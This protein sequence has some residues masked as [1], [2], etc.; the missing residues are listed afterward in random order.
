MGGCRNGTIP[1]KY[2]GLQETSSADY[3]K[4]TE[5]NVVDSDATVVFCYGKPTGGSALTVKLA[6]KHSRPC[7][8]VDLSEP[9]GDVVPAS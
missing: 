4:R 6:E 5:A 1:A 7:L 8:A 3:S 9:R 2:A